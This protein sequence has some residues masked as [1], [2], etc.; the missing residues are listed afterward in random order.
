MS[1]VSIAFNKCQVKT[2]MKD[3]V[4]PETFRKLRAISHGTNLHK[5]WKQSYWFWLFVCRKVLRNRGLNRQFSQKT[6]YYY[7]SIYFFKFNFSKYF[8]Y[9]YPDSS[10]NTPFP[11]ICT[12]LTLE[13]ETAL[14][15]LPLQR[16]KKRIGRTIL[17][18]EKE[19]NCI[20]EERKQRLKCRCGGRKDMA[21]NFRFWS[22]GPFLNGFWLWIIWLNVRNLNGLNDLKSWL[23]S[24][25]L[26]LI[27]FLLK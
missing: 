5:N 16:R 24:L 4:N 25:V 6:A 8:S 17:E 18:L 20:G 10:I 27:T 7:G 19:Q 22:I 21:H 3:I 15:K 2:S 26:R 13:T 11:M 9:K 14:A 23:T 12:H 1:H